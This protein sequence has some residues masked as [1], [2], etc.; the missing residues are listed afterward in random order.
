MR[1]FRKKLGKTQKSIWRKKHTDTKKGILNWENNM[2]LPYSDVLDIR[3]GGKKAIRVVG[4]RTDR[5]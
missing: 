4:V 2:Q 3:I 1:S 5:E